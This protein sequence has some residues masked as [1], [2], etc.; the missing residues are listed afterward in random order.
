ML[1]ELPDSKFGLI[2]FYFNSEINIALEPPA[3]TYLKQKHASGTP[4]V[5]SFICI[6]HPDLDHT[7]GV[8]KLFKWIRAEE[9]EVER[10]W[11]YPGINEGD[12][13]ESLA[14]ATAYLD[15]IVVENIASGIEPP[16]GL[17]NNSE[18]RRLRDDLREL[19]KFVEEWKPR[20]PDLLQGIVRLCNLGAEVEICPLAPLSDD[21]R[22]ADKKALRTLFL[23]TQN[24]K[25]L[26]LEDRNLVSSVIKI[27]FGEHQLLFGGDAG[28]GVWQRSL[29]EFDRRHQ[30]DEGPCFNSCQANFIKASHHGSKNSSSVKLW[31]RILGAPAHVA[32]SGG[33]GDKRPFPNRETIAHLAEIA[34]NS[35]GAPQ[36]LTTNVCDKCFRLQ[37]LPH[38]ELTWLPE[39]PKTSRHEATNEVV[40]REAP[41]ARLP[42]EDASLKRSK[43]DHTEKALTLV[44]PR[45][46]K[47]TTLATRSLGAYVFRFPLS[48]KEVL[49]SKASMPS[50]ERRDCV[51]N[52]KGKKRFPE[53]ALAK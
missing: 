11:L 8:E 25:P 41:G 42:E 22:R 50:G 36:L 47:S 7:T 10:L 18:I 38:E 31:E 17:R 35:K 2:D 32:F 29:D 15:E 6:S 45:P 3:L 37:E 13:G 23:W 14:R 43:H 5:L 9:I 40:S 1:L 34:E 53:C 28:E 21:I 12:I 33:Q 19:W 44:R 24:Q 51:Y 30:N 48:H 46:K 27:R 20:S 16:V 4:V 52:Y 49:V 26:K 39:S